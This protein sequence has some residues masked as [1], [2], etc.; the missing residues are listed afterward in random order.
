MFK[1]VYMLR[2]NLNDIFCKTWNI[3]FDLGFHMSLLIM[4]MKR[5]INTHPCSALT[6]ICRLPTL[7]YCHN[8]KR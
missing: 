5:G 1:T 8:C 6:L 2:F 3:H 7:I 4:L